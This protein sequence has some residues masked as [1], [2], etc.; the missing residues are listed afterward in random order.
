MRVDEESK[1]KL[2]GLWFLRP[3]KVKLKGVSKSQFEMF[4]RHRW[5]VEVEIK[6][7]KAHGLE[8]YMVP[9]CL[10]LLNW[11]SLSKMLQGGV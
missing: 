6:V 7:L 1:E 5:Q 9:L 10:G 2:G 8:S 4:Y 11:L 3:E